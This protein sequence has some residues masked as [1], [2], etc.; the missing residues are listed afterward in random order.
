M[1]SRPYRQIAAGQEYEEQGVHAA[2]AR[3]IEIAR[4]LGWPGP[5]FP[6]D[7]ELSTA[8]ASFQGDQ[9]DLEHL[10]DDNTPLSP[11]QRDGGGMGVVVSLLEK[12]KELKDTEDSLHGYALSGDLAKLKSL[13]VSSALDVD[14]R[15]EYVR[16]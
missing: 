5:S 12:P 11:K 15:D 1:C 2:E 4:S 6:A 10:D 3:Y 13:L 8:P 7:L 9:V 14:S 16:A